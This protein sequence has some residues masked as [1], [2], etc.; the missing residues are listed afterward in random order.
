MKTNIYFDVSPSVRLRM[1][2]VTGINCRENQNTFHFNNFSENSSRLWDN[3][4]KYRRAAQITADHMAH[5]HCLLDIWGHEHIR[6]VWNTYWLPTATMVS[7]TRLNITLHVK[8]VSCYLY[9]WLI[10]RSDISVKS[11]FWFLPPSKLLSF[12]CRGL[13]SGR[14]H[15]I[16]FSRTKQ[17]FW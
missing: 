2:N 10:L 4:Q 3:V 15:H 12:R 16:C 8:C 13:G 6:S 11:V 9:L 5:V 14:F 7:R 17:K 1:R